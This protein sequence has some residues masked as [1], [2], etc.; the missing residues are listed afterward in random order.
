MAEFTQQLHAKDSWLKGN[1]AGLP[2]KRQFVRTSQCLPGRAVAASIMASHAEYGSISRSRSLAFPA[3]AGAS[4]FSGKSAVAPADNRNVSRN[5][6]LGPL[7]RPLRA[8]T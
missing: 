1:I 8:L 2:R 7:S 6:S 5:V 3:L 4:L